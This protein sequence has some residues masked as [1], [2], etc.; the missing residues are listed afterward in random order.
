MMITYKEF[1][2]ENISLLLNNDSLLKEVFNIYDQ[3]M[4]SNPE[5]KKIRENFFKKELKKEGQYI[6]IA[7]QDKSPVAIT[8]GYLMDGVFNIQNVFVSPKHHGK[9]I[10]KKI[11]LRAIAYMSA[12]KKIERFVTLNVVNNKIYSIN[13]SIVER[14]NKSVSKTYSLEPK[15]SNNSNFFESNKTLKPK[16]NIIAKRQVRK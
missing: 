2:P 4:P 12:K 5:Y 6:F 9:G 3:G 15:K 16:T 10:G 13:N 7:F 11:Q 8:S 14:K 1:I